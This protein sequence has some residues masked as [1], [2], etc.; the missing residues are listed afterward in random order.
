MLSGCRHFFF[1]QKHNRKSR[2]FTSFSFLL[3]NEKSQNYGKWVFFF[4]LSFLQI[5]MVL[6]PWLTSD[7]FPNEVPS[8]FKPHHLP[9]S[10]IDDWPFHFTAHSLSKH[11]PKPQASTFFFGVSRVFP[12]FTV[13]S[14]RQ[15]VQA[16]VSLHIHHH[17]FRHS[18][19]VFEFRNL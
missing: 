5:F 4:F 14:G 13:V 10:C 18:I 16:R 2:P 8:K 9:F 7:I 12:T 1:M 3:Q 19:F 17:D 15:T 6:E 11:Q